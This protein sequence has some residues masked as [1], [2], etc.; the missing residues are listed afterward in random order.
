MALNQVYQILRLLVR[1]HRRLKIQL[2]GSIPIRSNFLAMD[3]HRNKKIMYTSERA[4]C[5][6]SLCP[7]TP[8]VPVDCGRLHVCPFLPF[9]IVLR[10]VLLNN[11]VLVSS[12]PACIYLFCTFRLVIAFRKLRSE[13]AL[14]LQ[15]SITNQPVFVKGMG[16]DSM[17]FD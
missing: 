2:H 3:Y 11:K 13:K 8:N 12:P 4:Q 6:R 10:V 17:T 15:T 5:Y 9:Y 7:K 16:S 14:V 1:I